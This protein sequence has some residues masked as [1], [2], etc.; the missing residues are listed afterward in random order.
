[1]GLGVDECVCVKLNGIGC[2]VGFLIFYDEDGF[3]YV[4][5]GMGLALNFKNV[6]I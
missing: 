4:V 3:W 6:W 5:D 1:V 2:V